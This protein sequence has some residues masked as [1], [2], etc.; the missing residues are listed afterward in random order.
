MKIKIL[1]IIIIFGLTA[2]NAK[3]A[4]VET[5]VS[6][7]KATEVT[8]ITDVTEFES[9]EKELLQMYTKYLNEYKKTIGGL[10]LGDINGDKIAELV[11]ENNS[12]DGTDIVYYNKNG[13]QVLSLETEVYGGDVTYMID[14]K[15][16]LHTTFIG[17]TT[18]TEGY[19]DKYLYSWNGTE[20]VI[21]TKLVRYMSD[22]GLICIINDS[23]VDEETFNSELEK[24][25]EISYGEYFPVITVFDENFENYLKETFPDFNNWDAIAK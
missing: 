19:I 16:I 9:I 2:C 4:D 10:Y 20:Y 5:T 15:Q 17:H 23:L 6:N 11:I 21:T 3:T 1:L 8:T 12:Y 13:L 7:A 22:N 14:T 18:G 24:Y 25:I